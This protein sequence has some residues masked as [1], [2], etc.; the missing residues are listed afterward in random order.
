MNRFS[1]A[2]AHD[3]VEQLQNMRQGGSSISQYID[4]FEECMALVKRDH[5]YTQ[6]AFVMSCFIGG[7]R[8]EIKHDMSGQRPQGLLEAY[9]Y[10]RV[11]EKASAKKPHQSGG[12]SRNKFNAVGSSQFKPTSK[13]VQST[14][15]RNNFGRTGTNNGE[16]EK[17]TCWYCQELWSM[18]HKCK[19]KKAIHALLLREDGEESLGE[20]EDTSVEDGYI[21]APDSPK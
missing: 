3:A 13:P 9:W 16:K 1:E 14:R 10:S 2:N 15:D 5:P 7:L 19:V 21:T 6:E 12:Y 8:S 18:N 20:K 17:R 11:Y 4:K